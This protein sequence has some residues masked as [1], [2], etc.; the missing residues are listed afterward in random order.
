MKGIKRRQ[1]ARRVVV[2]ALYLLNETDQVTVDQAIEFALESG[3]FPEEGY[4]QLEEPYLHELVQGVQNHTDDLDSK[5]T[6]YLIN[7]TLDRIAKIDLIILR[8]AFYEIFYQSD[9]IVP[10]AVAVNE[11]IELTKVFSDDRSRQFVSGV[12][13]QAMDALKD[14]KNNDE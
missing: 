2:Q 6:P 9:E 12:L 13:A 5:I 4:G 7:W 8:I 1:A 14:E 3:N 10:P 11:A